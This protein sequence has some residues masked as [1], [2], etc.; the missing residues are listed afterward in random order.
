[1]KEYN[2]TFDA[3]GRITYTIEANSKEEAYEKFSRGDNDVI[4]TLDDIDIDS[5]QWCW[6]TTM[7]QYFMENV[8]EN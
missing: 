3:K 1:M 4:Q 6:H 5:S 2:I 7:E 8:E